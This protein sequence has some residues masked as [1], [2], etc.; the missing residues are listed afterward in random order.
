MVKI[1]F[2]IKSNFAINYYELCIIT[3]KNHEGSF[4]SRNVVDDHRNLAIFIR[5]VEIFVGNS[6]ILTEILNT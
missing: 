1:K 4:T 2:Y 3:A 6:E 5:N